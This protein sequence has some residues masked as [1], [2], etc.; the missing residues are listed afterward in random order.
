M[1]IDLETKLD[2][3]PE[4][5]LRIEHGPKTI[6]NLCAEKSIYAYLVFPL[7]GDKY[8]VDLTSMQEFHS[9]GSMDLETADAEPTDFCCIIHKNSREFWIPEREQRNEQGFIVPDIS[10]AVWPAELQEILP[11][12]KEITTLKSK[13]TIASRVK[14]MPE[15]YERYFEPRK[16]KESLMS[17]E[18]L[19]MTQLPVTALHVQEDFEYSDFLGNEGFTE[20]ITDITVRYKYKGK[21]VHAWVQTRSLGGDADEFIDRKFG[22][23]HHVTYDGYNADSNFYLLPIVEPNGRCCLGAILYLRHSVRDKPEFRVLQ[24]VMERLQ[25]KKL[26]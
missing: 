25:D 4:S 23:R 15:S 22:T 10:P 12:F 17:L 16:Q 6:D 7:N 8:T 2:F 20:T 11:L 13:S 9:D 1:D 3:T 19:N 18:E 14:R 24:A 5:F 21:L 26:Q